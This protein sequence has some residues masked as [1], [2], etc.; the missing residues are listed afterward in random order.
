MGFTLDE[1]N[2]LNKS[3]L[4][5]LFII[6]QEYASF[7]AMTVHHDALCQLLANLVRRFCSRSAPTT[8]SGWVVDIAKSLYYSLM[9]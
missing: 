2:A 6:S 4:D 3:S 9:S 5:E 8:P 1:M 7:L